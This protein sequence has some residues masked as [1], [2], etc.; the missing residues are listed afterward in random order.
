MKLLLMRAAIVLCALAMT[1]CHT[2]FT[3]PPLFAHGSS[4][5]FDMA[6]T[7]YVLIVIPCVYLLLVSRYLWGGK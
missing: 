7:M 5:A 3:A 4:S 2:I 1:A 6:V